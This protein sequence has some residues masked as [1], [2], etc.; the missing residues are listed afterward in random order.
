[1]LQYS[2]FSVQGIVLDRDRKPVE[3][4]QVSDLG[5]HGFATTHADGTFTLSG[6]DAGVWKLRARYHGDTSAVATRTVDADHDAPYIELVLG[7]A[8]NALRVA[9]SRDA[10]PAGGALVFM[11]SAEGHLYLSTAD[12]SGTASFRI[13]DPVPQRVRI[14]ANVAGAWTLGDWM[15]ADEAMK[16][17]ISLAIGAT[18]EIVVRSK[19]PTGTVMITRSDG[20]RIDRLLQWL[21][22]F[23]SLSAN[24]DVSVTGLP[25]G[26]YTIAVADQQRSV[27]VAEGKSVE[28]LFEK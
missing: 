26:T 28:T 12:A 1:V 20:W 21:G 2:G 7:A 19:A 9:V 23:L 8:E 6:P 24:S 10:H 13:E 16:K 25:P 22:S 3:G 15:P 4:A 18:G 11:E 27:S 5:G 14:A 17:G